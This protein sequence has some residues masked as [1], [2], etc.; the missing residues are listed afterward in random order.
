MYIEVLKNRKECTFEANVEVRFLN[1]KIKYSMEKC[2][3]QD[4]VIFDRIVFSKYNKNI[5]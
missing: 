2:T 1:M 5:G 4:W 3:K